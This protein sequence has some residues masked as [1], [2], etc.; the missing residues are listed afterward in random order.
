MDTACIFKRIEKKYL[1][2]EE[3]YTSLFE[4][5]GVLGDMYELGDRAIDLH[6]EVGRCY[7][8]YHSYR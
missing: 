8:R 7:Q 6:R 1:L 4:R 3:Q 2:T 5:I